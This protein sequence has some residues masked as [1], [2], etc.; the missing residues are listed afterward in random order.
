[1]Q[2]AAI[3]PKL[4]NQSLVALV[5]AGALLSYFT[6]DI[7][8]LFI[9]AALALCGFLLP[10]LGLSIAV[11]WFYIGRVA[12]SITQPVILT[13]TFY[14]ILTPI[15]LLSRLFSKDSMWLKRGKYSYFRMEEKSFKKSDFEKTW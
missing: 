2:Q 5:I 11:V 8:I 12:G 10:A 1:M 14:L 4:I 6:S 13:I 15:A 9:A 7:R 3:S